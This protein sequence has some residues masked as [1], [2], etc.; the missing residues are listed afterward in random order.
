ML[1]AWKEEVKMLHLDLPGG[2]GVRVKGQGLG[3]RVQGLSV[4]QGLGF[5]VEGI[6]SAGMLSWGP[7]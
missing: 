2:G 4:F 3:F 7:L 1:N 5:R 6:G